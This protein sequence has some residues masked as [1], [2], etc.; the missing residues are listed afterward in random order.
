MHIPNSIYFWNDRTDHLC[1]IYVRNTTKSFS[2]MNKWQWEGC[3]QWEEEAK[4]WLVSMETLAASGRT[5]VE[6]EAEVRKAEILLILPHQYVSTIR[7]HLHLGQ[8]KPVD[9]TS[10]IKLEIPIR[11]FKSQHARSKWIRITYSVT[12]SAH[13][14]MKL[15]SVWKSVTVIHYYFCH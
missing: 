4:S 10:C 8:I 2:Q 5:A 6:E 11:T 7:D 1:V 15:Q 13:V 12:Y 14:D 3:F 9:Y